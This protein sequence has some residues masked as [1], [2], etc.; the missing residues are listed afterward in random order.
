[1]AITQVAQRG[2]HITLLVETLKSQCNGSINAGIVSIWEGILGPGLG[3]G[4]DWRG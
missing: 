1:M 2:C 4:A 3:V